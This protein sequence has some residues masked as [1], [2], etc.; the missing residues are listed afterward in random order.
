MVMVI[1]RYQG[2]TQ[3]VISEATTVFRCF[4][5]YSFFS[6][7]IFSVVLNRHSSFTIG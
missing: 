2:Y 5:R 1:P 4:L 7:T 3:D 6:M